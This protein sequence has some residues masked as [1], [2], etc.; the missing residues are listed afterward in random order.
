MNIVAIGGGTGLSTLLSG[1]KHYVQP[2]GLAEPRS[3]ATPINTI[4]AIVTVSDDG[5]S[6]GRLRE[7]FQMLPPGDIRN[8]M[9]ALSEDEQLMSRL[10]RHRFGGKGD[11]SGHSFGNIFLTALTSV[12]G[13]FLEAIRLSSE[14]LAIK[15]RIFPATMSDVVLAAELADGTRVE[16][17]SNISSSTSPIAK[18]HL[19]PA[20]VYPL[21]D[22]VRAIAEADLITLGP[23]SL[24]TSIL[25]NLLVQ[26]IPEALSRS[27]AIKVYVCNLMTQPGETVGF[28]VNDHVQT[29]FSYAPELSLDYVIVNS[30]LIPAQLRARY[31][32]EGAAQIG[33]DFCETPAQPAEQIINQHNQTVAQVICTDLLEVRKIQDKEWK[34][35]IRHNPS[36]LAQVILDLAQQPL[37]G[38]GQPDDFSLAQRD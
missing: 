26:G 1:L 36:K 9:V 35:V 2:D 6:S 34:D 8:C 4:T 30:A 33:V 38:K 31:E 15:G 14:V 5:G 7:E 11:L 28:S 22:T 24:F 29:V 32:A 16:G 18:L 23:G 21:E 10:F 17:E 37:R 12:T 13:D 27:A 3:T 19:I 20:T 25:P